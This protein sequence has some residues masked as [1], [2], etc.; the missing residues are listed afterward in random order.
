MTP[1]LNSATEFKSD[2]KLNPVIVKDT[3]PPAVA[4]LENKK[5]MVE[6]TAKAYMYSSNIIP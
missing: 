2:S 3:W 6:T 1:P 5:I 4:R